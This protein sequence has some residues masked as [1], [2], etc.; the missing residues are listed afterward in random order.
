MVASIHVCKHP[1][2]QVSM[3]AH[4][5]PVQKEL[6]LSGVSCREELEQEEEEREEQEQEGHKQEAEE[7]HKEQDEKEEEEE[8]KNMFPPRMIKELAFCI[9]ITNLINIAINVSNAKKMTV[10]AIFN[11]FCGRSFFGGT[12][13][14]I[15]DPT[16]ASAKLT[17][18]EIQTTIKGISRRIGWKTR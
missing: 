10:Q 4:W 1:C 14:D 18:H 6:T 3:V 17:K 16:S 8:G 12:S 13:S 7:G 5:L 2:L 9:G 11:L 15:V